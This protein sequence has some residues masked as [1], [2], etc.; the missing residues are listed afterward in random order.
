MPRKV[1]AIAIAVVK[2]KKSIESAEFCLEYTNQTKLWIWHSIPLDF[3]A[4]QKQ[5]SQSQK[6]RDIL[7]LNHFKYHEVFAIAIAITLKLKSPIISK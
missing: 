2:A 5:Q 7:S 6:P 1:F 3:L 4:L